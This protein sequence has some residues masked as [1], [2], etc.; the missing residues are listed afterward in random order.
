MMILAGRS[1]LNGVDNMAARLTDEQKKRIIADYVESGS[2]RATARK[3]GVVAD[4]VKRIVQSDGGIVQKATQKKA[5]NTLDMLEYMDKRKERAQDIIDK[6]L[7]ALADPEKLENATLQ[8]IATALG[9]VVDKFTRST[10]A[11]ENTL[12]KLDEVLKEIG[13]VV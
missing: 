8:Q 13:G 10:P 5:E 9:I 12:A 2:Y 1:R 6:Y 11:G 3:N 7:E 4:T